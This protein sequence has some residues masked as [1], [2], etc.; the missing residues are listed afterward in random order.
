[1]WAFLLPACNDGTNSLHPFVLRFLLGGG[2]GC[3]GVGGVETG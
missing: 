3:V 2:E 1:M